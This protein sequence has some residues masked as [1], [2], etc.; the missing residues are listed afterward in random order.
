MTETVAASPAAT[1]ARR[2]AAVSLVAVLAVL[3]GGFLLVDGVLDA[4]DVS[5]DDEGAIAYTALQIALGLVALAIA[6]GALG[7]RPW[8]W[9]L[10][11][12]LAVVGLTTQILQYFFFDDPHYLR[13]A[14]YAFI[15]FVLTPRDM[16][17]AF[18]IRPPA[19][20]DLDRPT[21]NPLDR[22]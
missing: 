1:E 16:Q 17:I 2:P 7:V 20:V 19:N 3:A 6:I 8:G 21:R 22:E 4:R 5:R 11:M 18:G 14:I 15:V 9:K 10:F 13:M 12:T